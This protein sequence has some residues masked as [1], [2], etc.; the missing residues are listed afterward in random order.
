LLAVA[1]CTA[2]VATAGSLWYSLGMGLVPCRLCWYQRILMYPLVVVCWDALRSD[3]AAPHRTILPLAIPG[4]AIAAYHTYI[5]A[6]P[7]AT[8]AT[9]GCG[10]VQ[11]RLLYV[12]TIPNQS[13]LAFAVVTLATLAVWRI[14]CREHT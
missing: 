14:D 3:R 8:C 10:T 4:L 13:L 7:Q 9:F 6:V 1:A 5:Q 12:L 11:F 2:T